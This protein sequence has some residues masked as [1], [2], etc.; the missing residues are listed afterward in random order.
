MSYRF[1]YDKFD[2]KCI[3]FG[4]CK[5]VSEENSF[6]SR[7]ECEKICGS[8]EWVS[9]VAMLFFC[10]NVSIKIR[11]FISSELQNW[12][13]KSR[14]SS[15]W[16]W[17]CFDFNRYALQNR[18]DKNNNHNIKGVSNMIL[19]KVICMLRKCEKMIF[20]IYIA[21]H[22]HK[23]H[24]RHALS[25]LGLMIFGAYYGWKY[26]KNWRNSPES[27]RMFGDQRSNSVL[28]SKIKKK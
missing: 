28:N 20:L 10:V 25:Y 4:G 12:T 27:Y 13:Y 23:D 7:Y 14:I 11:E 26:Y 15:S 1:F 9:F 5:D 6:P 21:Y 3:K 8:L 19:V 17:S 24:V 22:F 18:N 2:Q 16:C